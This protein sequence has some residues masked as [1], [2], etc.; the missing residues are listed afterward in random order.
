MHTPLFSHCVT[1]I[2]IEMSIWRLAPNWRLTKCYSSA[3]LFQGWN[4]QSFVV[5]TEWSR[6]C[7]E[8]GKYVGVWVPFQT[9]IWK[10]IA[11]INKQ[12]LLLRVLEGKKFVKLIILHMYLCIYDAHAAGK[13]SHLLIANFLSILKF[14][15][16]I[17]WTCSICFLTLN[18]NQIYPKWNLWKQLYIFDKQ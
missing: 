6:V 7:M 5:A 9:F 15:W 3:A 18:I 16:T 13:M 1:L 14:I 12:I 11:H 10:H 2:L 17:N 4:K 8:T